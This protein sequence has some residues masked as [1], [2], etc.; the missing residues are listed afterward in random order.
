[1]KPGIPKGTRDFGPSEVRKRN[2]IFRTIKSVFEKCGY[3]PLETPVLEKLSTLTGKYGEEGDKLLF[4]VLNNGDYLA[5]ADKTALEQGDSRKLLPSISKRGM[6][7]DLTVPFARYVVMHQH[8]LA[9]PFKRFQIQPVWRAD[10]PQKGRYQEFYQCDADVIGSDALM[11][12]A[13]LIHIFDQVFA[14]LDLSVNVKINNRKILLGIAEVA[15]IEDQF[16]DMT[17]AIDKLD[18]IGQDGVQ[19]ELEKRSIPNSAIDFILTCIMKSDIVSLEAQ[20]QANEHAMQGIKEVKSVLAYL[21]HLDLKNKVEIDLTLARGLNYYTGCIIE[22]VSNDVVMG[23]LGG[24]GRYDDLTGVFGLKAMSGVGISFGAARI[25]DVLTELDRFPESLNKSIDLLLI[26]LDAAAHE[27]AFR[28]LH[29]LRSSDISS[30]LYPSPLKLKKQ[31]KYANDIS[32]PWVA[33]IGEEELKTG[34]VMLKNMA[35]GEQT[36]IETTQIED[37]I[38]K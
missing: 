32:V 21:D 35:S 26:A 33:I 9:F 8:E 31:M 2:Y 36:A 38:R 22:V 12:E 6:R 28:L 3:Q 27:S 10:R 17:V 16:I 18:K 15:K 1:M 4:K 30:D 11:Y 14:T 25:Y 23:S 7:Y 20:L 5:K 37:F 19:K 13:E 29:R 24:G 34:K